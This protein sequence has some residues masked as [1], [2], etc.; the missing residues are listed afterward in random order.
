MAEP[1]NHTEIHKM[2]KKH[3]K[4]VIQTQTGTFKLIKE[5]G[6][7]FYE[8]NGCVVGISEKLLN[9]IVDR[10]PENIGVIGWE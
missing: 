8:V 5:D 9:E 7:Y 1:T 6:R 10:V 4:V 2:L 3:G